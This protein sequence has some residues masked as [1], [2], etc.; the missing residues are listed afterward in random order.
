MPQNCAAPAPDHLECIAAQILDKRRTDL[1]VTEAALAADVGS[2]QPM[3]HRWLTAQKSPPLHF[4][5]R[6]CDA[7]GLDYVTVLAE[8]RTDA[9]VISA[10]EA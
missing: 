8:A 6:M 5:V 10:Q 2:S 9:G 7:L 3:V 1:G 4:F